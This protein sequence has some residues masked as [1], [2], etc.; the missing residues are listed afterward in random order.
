MALDSSVVAER[1]S[2]SNLLRG[3]LSAAKSRVQTTRGSDSIPS[4]WQIYDFVTG[5]IQRNQAH[6]AQF[7]AM[8]ITSRTLEHTLGKGQIVERSFSPLARI[9]PLESVRVSIDSVARAAKAFQANS[10]EIEVQVSRL[11]NQA[12]RVV[13]PYLVDDSTIGALRGHMERG[14]P[15]VL[16]ARMLGREWI[17]TG[18]LQVLFTSPWYVPSVMGV[19]AAFNEAG[20]PTID[21]QH[22]QQ[23]PFQSMYV[24]WEPSRFNGISLL[25]NQFWVWGEVTKERISPEGR[26]DNPM[27]K[28]V[29]YPFLRDAKQ[30]SLASETYRSTETSPRIKPRVLVAL[31][32]SHLDL[33]GLLPAQLREFMHRSHATFHLRP[34]PNYPLSR[35]T[36]KELGQEFGS[37]VQVVS[38]E[39][40]LSLSISTYDLLLTGFSSSALE[41]ASM[42]IMSLLWAPVAKDQYPALVSSGVF[43]VDPDLT[44][45]LEEVLGKRKNVNWESVEPYI[46]SD[47]KLLDLAVEQLNLFERINQGRR[48]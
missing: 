43:T 37:N 19:I 28:V 38:C 21:L 22:G 39:G 2:L 16:Q 9:L 30:F 5:A 42:G 20:L 29:G 10:A 34:H 8:F 1:S 6:P 24:G 36:L 3:K 44:T 23:G 40:A 18:Q 15:D 48:N 35:R 11:I 47:P 17:S 4:A 14:I 13:R 25:P 46:S 12:A 7:D 31:Q 32:G 26:C 41:A 27:V 33:E 45:S